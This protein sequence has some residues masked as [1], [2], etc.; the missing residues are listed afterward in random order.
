MIQINRILVPTD[1]ST[2]AQSAVLHAAYMAESTGAEV[3]LLH[4]SEGTGN[5]RNLDLSALPVGH[6]TNPGTKAPGEEKCGIQVRR[7]VLT[8][9]GVTEK[10]LSYTREHEIDLIVMGAH[11]DSGANRFLIC[12]LDYLLVGTTAEEIVRRAC[13]PVLTV[14]LRRGRYPGLIK[15]ILVAVDLSA[16]DIRSIGYARELAAIYKAEL[17]LLHILEPNGSGGSAIFQPTSSGEYGE[18]TRTRLV[19]IYNQSEGPAVAVNF[20]VV[21]GKVARDLSIFAEQYDMQLIVLSSHRFAS[22]LSDSSDDGERINQLAAYSV[23]TTNAGIPKPEPSD[24]EKSGT[25]KT[26]LPF[27]TTLSEYVVTP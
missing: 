5:G 14:G 1:F 21:P 22:T 24:R 19:E 26:H 3:H 17:N 15:R 10:I 8:G 25:R 9:P 11:G 6:P 16:P 18:F 12:G 2:C 13:C 4:V 23:L 20:H 7:A 27:D